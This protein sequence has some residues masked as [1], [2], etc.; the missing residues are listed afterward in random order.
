MFSLRYEQHVYISFRRV[1]YFAVLELHVLSVAAFLKTSQPSLVATEENHEDAVRNV[2]CFGFG[3]QLKMFLLADYR[4]LDCQMFID[5]SA[6][7]TA[8]T[9][10]PWFSLLCTSH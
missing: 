8:Y 5:V 1:L 2:H 9:L 4:R 6:G 3:S 7:L 10:L